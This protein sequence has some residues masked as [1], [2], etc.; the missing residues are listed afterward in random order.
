VEM[1]EKVVRLSINSGG[2]YLC[3][4]WVDC[5]RRPIQ[6]RKTAFFPPLKAGRGTITQASVRGKR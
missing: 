2:V 6:E 5:R 1:V 4:D 3:P